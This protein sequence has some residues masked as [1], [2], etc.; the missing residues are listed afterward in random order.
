V[1]LVGGLALSG[2]IGALVAVPLIATVRV[3]GRYIHRKLVGIPPWPT[4]TVAAETAVTQQTK[5]IDEE[6]QKPSLPTS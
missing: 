1:G 3:I 2:F 5:E 4:T 6:S